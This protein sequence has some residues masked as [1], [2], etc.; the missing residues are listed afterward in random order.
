MQASQPKAS[1]AIQFCYWWFRWQ[2]FKN[3]W[4]SLFAHIFHRTKNIV[5]LMSASQLFDYIYYSSTNECSKVL[6]DLWEFFDV[7]Q[8]FIKWLMVET[9]ENELRTN[10]RMIIIYHKSK[11][12]F[13]EWIPS[14]C[15]S[16][17][18]STI[19]ASKSV[20]SVKK[21]H[22][23]FPLT[24]TIEHMHFYAIVKVRNSR[25]SIRY[26]TFTLSLS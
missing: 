20:I 5:S 12:D 26:L 24:S 9:S 17:E 15:K 13:L 1:L 21:M 16:W 22:A 8:L 2:H 7:F 23:W 3:V 4:S 25:K 14:N 18:R 19:S 11:R 10:F 6:K